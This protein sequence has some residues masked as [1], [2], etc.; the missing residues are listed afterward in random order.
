M[1]KEILSVSLGNGILDNDY[2]FYEDG[3][4]IHEYDQSIYKPNQKSKLT[5]AQIDD[6]TFA[7]IVLK[8]TES[9]KIILD[10][11]VKRFK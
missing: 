4:V 5:L 7:S 9:E 1:N 3:T 6:K 2:V 11:L 8:L 10:E